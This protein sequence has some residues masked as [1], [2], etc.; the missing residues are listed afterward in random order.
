MPSMFEG[1]KNEN[2][3]VDDLKHDISPILSYPSL[4]C[5]NSDQGEFLRETQQYKKLQKKIARIK[6]VLKRNELQYSLVH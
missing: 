2:D 3:R 1:L 5:C 4:Y 6:N